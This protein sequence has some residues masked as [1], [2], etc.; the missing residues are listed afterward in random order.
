MRQ[1]QFRPLFDFRNKRQR[2]LSF[3]PGARRDED[4]Y[5]PYVDPDF[6]RQGGR[7]SLSPD[8]GRRLAARRLEA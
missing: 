1:T 6:D 5:H 2:M 4:S 3:S 8:T 7:V